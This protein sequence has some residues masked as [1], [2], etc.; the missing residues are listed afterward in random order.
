MALTTAQ[1]QAALG[2]EADL[3]ARLLA[4]ATA[5]VARY[6]LQSV[7]PDSVRDEAIVRVAGFLKDRP[8]SNLAGEKYGDVELTYAPSQ[9][10]AIR[11]S[12]AMSLLSPFRIRRGG[13]I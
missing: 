12:G 3:S 11:A 6:L 13:R 10:S 9:V 8:N 1:L 5:I 4:V 7:V 2:I